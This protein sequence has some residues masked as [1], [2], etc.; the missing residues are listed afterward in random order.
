MSEATAVV[1]PEVA[2]EGLTEEVELTDEPVKVDPKSRVGIMISVP[3]ELKQRIEDAAKADGDKA[4]ASWVRDQ[5]AELLNYTLPAS[6]R[7]RKSKYATP[8]ERKE[9]AK[10]KQK[11]RYEAASTL[12]EA[13]NAG[14][15][16]LDALKAAIAAKSKS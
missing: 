11:Q 10:A 7:T 15:I 13:I 9:A 2:V 4:A 3:I 8:E 14:V 1:E 6:T 12:L 5:I 16:D